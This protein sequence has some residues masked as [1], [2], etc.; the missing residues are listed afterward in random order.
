M[1]LLKRSAVKHL[2]WKRRAMAGRFG[3]HAG[4]ELGGSPGR[5]TALEYS[6]LILGHPFWKKFGYKSGRQ[7]CGPCPPSPGSKHTAISQETAQTS[8]PPTVIY[9]RTLS[10]PGP[11]PGFSVHSSA[12]R[13]DVR[14]QPCQGWRPQQ[15]ASS[16]RGT[17][18]LPMA[19]PW[20]A[21]DQKCAQGGQGLGSGQ[22]SEA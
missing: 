19:C 13:P 17:H 21:L 2:G 22:E 4:A 5:G 8:R 15:Q 1:D 7:M 3:A 14:T 20:E 16:G 11:G 6:G 12:G 9:T 10:P 18:Y